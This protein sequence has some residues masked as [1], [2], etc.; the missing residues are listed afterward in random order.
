[1]K[2]IISTAIKATSKQTLISSTFLALLLSTS[3]CSSK[4]PQ[5][6]GGFA[7]HT[8]HNYSQSPSHPIG[9]ENALYFEQLLAQRHLDALISAGANICFPANVKTAKLRQARITRQLNG[10]LEGDAANDLIIQRDQLNRLERRL[11]YVQ[12]QD[13]CMPEETYAGNVSGNIAAL[14]S[15]KQPPENNASSALTA[16][17]QQHLHTLLNN[18]NQFVSNSTALN[19]RYIGQLSE[20]VQLLRDYPQYHLKITGHSDSKGN[21]EANLKLSLARAAQVERY[22][23]IFGLSPNNIEVHGS[24]ES[25]PFFDATELQIK[26]IETPLDN[27]QTQVQLINRRVSIELIDAQKSSQGTLR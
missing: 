21:S 15:K 23:L 6:K 14:T 1:M 19:P 24:G 9:L 12:L 18:N 22:L 3:G 5:G 11:N 27:K 2:R 13:S 20:V 26:S 16:Q 4:A 7:E 25:E 10:G 8:E 17:Q